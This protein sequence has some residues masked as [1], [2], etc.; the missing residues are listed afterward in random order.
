MIKQIYVDMTIKKGITLKKDV[1]VA[2]ASCKS[3][4]ELVLIDEAYMMSKC[5][6]YDLFI[7][8]AVECKDYEMQVLK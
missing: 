7:P 5:E 1:K 2:C 8:I 3:C 6:V 4:K